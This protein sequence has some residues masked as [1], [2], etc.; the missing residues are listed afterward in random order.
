MITD[1]LKKDLER[2]KSIRL[3]T[4]PEFK[5]SAIGEWYFA[6]Q[7]GQL[8]LGFRPLILWPDVLHV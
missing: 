6:V 1:D 2:L 3:M 4:N 5:R 8:E 7:C